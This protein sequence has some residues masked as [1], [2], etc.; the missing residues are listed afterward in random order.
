MC[1]LTIAAPKLTMAPGGPASYVSPAAGEHGN[2]SEALMNP[3]VVPLLT[4]VPV[5]PPLVVPV[6]EDPAA[7]AAR[8]ALE[9]VAVAA[10][11]VAL[12][13]ALILGSSTPAGGPG[14][15]QPH[16]AP[17]SHDE[18]RLQELVAKHAVG[19]LGPDE[20]AELIVLLGKIKGIHVTRLAELPTLPSG[21]ADANAQPRGFITRINPLDEP[22]NKQAL[23]RE[24]ESAAI[25]ARAGY[26]VEQNPTI[27]GT[28]RNPDYLIEGKIFDCYSPTNSKPRSI[29]TTLE[30]KIKKGQA[31]R[32]I[33]NLEDSKVDMVALHQQFTQHPVGGL[34]EIIIIKQN[35]VV[36]FF[37]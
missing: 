28:T 6:A 27:R 29:A 3:F 35:K 5:I 20:E 14:I 10:A 30:G 26:R 9:G 19:A 1:H 25:L 16:F 13:L 12:I 11:P 2:P 32:F 18:L 4:P 7:T 33:L 37:P 8:M 24:N 22:E 31:E 23:L 15:P 34:Q 21:F 17:V 36:P